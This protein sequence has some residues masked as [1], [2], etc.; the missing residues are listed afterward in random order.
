MRHGPHQR[1]TSPTSVA[2]DRNLT[3]CKVWWDT[4]STADH[5]SVGFHPW[6]TIEA[7]RWLSSIAAR[8]VPCSSAAK[9][10]NNACLVG[11][12]ACGPVLRGV[13]RLIACSRASFYVAQPSRAIEG[14]H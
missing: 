12:Y 7:A 4:V 8:T 9:R 3:V 14:Y 11:A 5:H 2:A 10:S 13:S 6:L 1:R